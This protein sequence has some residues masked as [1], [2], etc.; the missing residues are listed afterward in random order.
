MLTEINRFM[1][2]EEIQVAYNLPVS[3]VGKI[4]P[5]LR[6]AAVQDDGTPLFLESE[7]DQ[8]IAELV[9]AQRLA[10]ARANPP[11]GKKPG[12]KDETAEIAAYAN[13]FVHKKSWLDVWRLCQKRWPGNPHVK[14]KERVRGIWRR[15]YEKKNRIE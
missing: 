8:F 12:R 1:T 5:A 11:P 6:V 4:Q 10:E 13:Q 7:V 9:Q 2:L 15:H 3:L 14:T